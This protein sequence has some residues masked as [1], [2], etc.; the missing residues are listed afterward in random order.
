MIGIDART[1]KRLDGDAHLRQS[2]ADILYTPIG[3]RVGLRDYGSLLLELIDKAMN[4]AGRLRL[5]AAIAD[6]LRRWEPRIRLIRVRLVDAD[7]ATMAGGR[8]SIEL[9]CV[10][11]DVAAPNARAT[12]AIPLPASF[13]PA[14][15]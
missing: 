4:P 6:A 15:A 10:R 1:G 2:I 5:V 9:E 8:F 7:P 3:S 12:L 11:T 13:R 14:T